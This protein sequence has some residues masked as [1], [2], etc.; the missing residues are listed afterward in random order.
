MASQIIQHD[1]I[2]PSKMSVLLW[3]FLILVSHVP[4]FASFYRVARDLQKYR[5]LHISF[6]YDGINVS[7]QIPPD[8]IKLSEMSS[9]EL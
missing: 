6:T 1:V 3:N 4:I 9:K 8:A 5:H 2:S 7:L